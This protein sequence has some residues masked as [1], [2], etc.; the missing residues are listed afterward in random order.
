MNEQPKILYRYE[1]DFNIFGVTPDYSIALVECEV[2]RPTKE[3]YWIKRPYSRKERWVS[4]TTTKRYAYP[5]K[6]EAY[7]SF[8]IRAKHAVKHCEHNLT[9]A[10]KFLKLVENSPVN[11]PVQEEVD[12][13]SF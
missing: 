7:Q 5:T 3:G 10:N 13:W 9:T 11:G 8:V 2:L 12:E 6:A 1:R 4:K